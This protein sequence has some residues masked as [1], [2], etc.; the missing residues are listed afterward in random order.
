M[1]RGGQV[2]ILQKWQSQIFILRFKDLASS[3]ILWVLE[4]NILLNYEQLAVSRQMLNIVPC[5][6][7]GNVMALEIPDQ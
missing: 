4:K 6:Y 7:G 1:D 3:Q 2:N 5:N